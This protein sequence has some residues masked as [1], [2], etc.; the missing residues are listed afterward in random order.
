MV[1]Q[2][3]VIIDAFKSLKGERTIQEIRD[4]II[5]NYDCQW[6]D[7]GTAMADMVL[8]SEGGNKSSQV[9][10][11]YRVLRRVSRGKYCLK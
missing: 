5:F 7:I 6:K 4:W 8:E 9:P 2:Y 3:E 11:P 10:A 1:N